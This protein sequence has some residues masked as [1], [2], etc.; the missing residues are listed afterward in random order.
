[1]LDHQRKEGTVY[2]G[3]LRFSIFSTFLFLPLPLSFPLLFLCPIQPY[4]PIPPS[5]PISLPLASSSNNGLHLLLLSLP[6]CVSYM[7]NVR[8]YVLRLTC[9]NT[10]VLCSPPCRTP[11]HPI[12]HSPRPSTFL[13][14]RPPHTLPIP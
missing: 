8:L 7:Y 10:F 5:S 6:P 2:Q 4:S 13:S 14:N 1:M 12:S 9:T 11:S 3:L